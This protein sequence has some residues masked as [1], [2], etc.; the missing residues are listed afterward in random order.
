MNK[1]IFLLIA[2]LM[3]VVT[4]AKAGKYDDALKERGTITFNCHI[5]SEEASFEFTNNNGTFSLT[6]RDGGDK[7]YYRAVTV[8]AAL[9]GKNITFYLDGR[10]LMDV[11]GEMKVVVYCDKD[12]ISFSK[13]SKNLALDTIV[14]VVPAHKH[15]YSK[16]WSKDATAHWHECTSVVGPCDAAKSDSAAHTFGT[17]AAARYTCEVCKYV[18]NAKK[19]VA[20]SIDNAA[21]DTVIAKIDAVVGKV[22]A[23]V[24]FV[25]ADTVLQSQLNNANAAY[26]KLTDGQKE[27]VPEEKTK[28]LAAAQKSYDKKKADAIDKA[29]ADTVIAKIDA[30][31]AKVDA[32][33]AYVDADSVLQAE[34]DNANKAYN[35]LTDAQKE[36]VSKE[37][38]D[39]LAAAQ[40]SYDQKKADAA[41]KAAADADKAA[42]DSVNALIES[43]GTVEYNDDVKT[44]IEG[45]RSAYDS[46]TDDQKKLV[47]NL[48]TLKEAEAAFAELVK[49][50]TIHSVT[51]KSGTEDADKWKITPGE[52]KNGTTVTVEYSGEKKV[53]SVKAVK[54]EKKAE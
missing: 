6:N 54:V 29:A 3:V 45:A 1:R 47:T 51:I 42:A 9:S 14:A 13:V 48:D 10:T 8:S 15:A 35:E 40:K 38:T 26:D 50:N 30:V 2:L 52:G 12:S 33:E 21:A 18:D 53:K 19:A 46:L 20:D 5:Y 39:A 43:I 36:L 22:D 17:E 31:V 44:K 28:A 7:G 27:L 24:N 32:I 23:I 25:D 49:N 41:A 4:G 11:V 16:D 37:K 34:L